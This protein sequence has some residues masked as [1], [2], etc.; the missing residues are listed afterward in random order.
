M[1]IQNKQYTYSNKLDSDSVKA[2]EKEKNVF[3]KN[4]F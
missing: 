3:K 2:D 1:T 4:T